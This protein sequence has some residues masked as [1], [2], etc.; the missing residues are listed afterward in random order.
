MRAAPLKLSE[1]M[2]LTH[3][4]LAPVAEVTVIQSTPLVPVHWQP[5]TALTV[6]VKKENDEPT[7]VFWGVTLGAQA[8]P[9]APEPACVIVTV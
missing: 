1:T 4:S 3:P 6:N 5:P 8:P 9:S 2:M 7:E